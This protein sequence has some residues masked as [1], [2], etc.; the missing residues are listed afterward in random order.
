MIATRYDGIRARTCEPP[1]TAINLHLD[2][3]A[4][5]AIDRL[6]DHLPGTTSRRRVAG[7]APELVVRG[8]T[9]RRAPSRKRT[10]SGRQHFEGGRSR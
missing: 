9:L 5:L 7:P 6:F 1:L 2:E 10:G 8:S 4:H 3:V